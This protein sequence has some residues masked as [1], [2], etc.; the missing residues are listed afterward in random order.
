M[1]KLK[2]G[3]KGEILPVEVKCPSDE[4][5]N[6]IRAYGVINACEWF[7]YS[8]EDDFTLETIRILCRRSGI[9]I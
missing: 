9:K 4:F 6:T 3:G 2:Y 1:I 8:S 5:E 7:G